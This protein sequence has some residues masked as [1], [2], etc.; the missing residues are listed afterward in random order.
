MNRNFSLFVKYWDEFTSSQ[1]GS[2]TYKDFLSGQKVDVGKQ[3]M[4]K[5]EEG[6][7]TDAKEEIEAETKEEVEEE[8]EIDSAGAEEVAAGAEKDAAG[9]EEDAAGAE[10]DAAGA[11]ED[12]AGAEEDAA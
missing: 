10:E 3:E 4:E 5:V 11:E 7:L 8:T 2:N 12:A 1:D 9:A 6:D